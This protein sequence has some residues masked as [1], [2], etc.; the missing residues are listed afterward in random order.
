MSQDN[1]KVIISLS[2][3]RIAYEYWQRDGEDKLVPISGG[4]WPAPLAFYCRPHGEIIIGQE[5][6]SAINANQQGAFDNFFGLLGS[7]VTYSYGGQTRH[8]NNLLLDASEPIFENFYREVLYF[9]PGAIISNRAS[10]PLSIVCESDVSGSQRAFLTREFTNAGYANV[11]VLMYDEYIGQ[12]I[13]DVLSEQF[14]CDYVL[15]AWTEGKDLTLS[16]FNKKQVKPVATT[17]LPNMGVDPRVEFVKNRIWERVLGQNGW[18]KTRR[19]EQETIIHDAAIQFLNSGKVAVNNDTVTLTDGRPYFYSLNRNEIT[20]NVQGEAGAKLRV[21]TE[22]FLSKNGLDVNKRKRVLLLLRGTAADNDYFVQNMGTGY[23]YVLKSDSKLR[24]KAMRLILEDNGG[25]E[26]EAEELEVEIY[27][28]P[29]DA[30]TVAASAQPQKQR[31][32]PPRPNPTPKPEKKAQPAQPTP[33]TPEDDDEI[34]LEL[35]WTEADIRKFRRN[36]REMKADVEGKI[37]SGKTAEAKKLLE[38]FISETEIQKGV[39]PEIA[40]A[41]ALL[42]GITP[43]AQPI[44]K[45]REPRHKDGEIHPNGKWVWVSSANGGKGD[46]RVLGGP[47]QKKSEKSEDSTVLKGATQT[48]SVAQ[49]VKPGTSKAQL[50]EGATLVSE[51]K[52]TEARNWFRQNGNP[53][54][55]ADLQRIIREQK[56]IDIRVA[57]IDSHR[58]AKNLEQIARIRTELKNFIELCEKTGVNADKYKQALAEYKKIK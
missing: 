48:P 12:Y 14:D 9:P 56:G 49:K 52:L 47:T 58:K 11:R 38:D 35:D 10:M 17:T 24:D 1:Y 53:E 46:W 51:G 15:V 50:S 22:D 55:A 8:I 23:A 42:D 41:R 20:L 4:D 45:A 18:M 2:H 44:A 32:T 27:E 36:W 6:I 13:K 33:P 54:M 30:E 26:P 57:T 5:A 29:V 39:E 28:G 21:M 3:H 25:K 7:D 37:R 40:Q 31:V 34:V 19:A 43:A 16:L